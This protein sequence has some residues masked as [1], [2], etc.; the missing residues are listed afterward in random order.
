M[1]RKAFI[2]GITGQDGSYLSEYLLSKGYEVHGFIRRCSV[3]NTLRIK[4]LLRNEKKGLSLHFGDLSNQEQMI[5]VLRSVKPDE[6]Y[7]LGA[8]SQV[9]ISFDIPVYTGDITALGTTRM[10]SAIHSID[11]NIKFYQASSSEM[12]GSAS[13][14]QNE[15]TPFYP[16]SPYAISKLY[17]YWTTV[18]YREAYNIFSCNGIMFNHESPRRGS[19]FV[20]KK[21]TETL[22]N[23]I[24]KKQ[25]KIRLGNINTKRDW[26]YAPDYVECMWKILQENIAEDYVIGSG[27]SHTVEEFL[28]N[29]FKYVGLD[30]QEYLEIDNQFYRPLDVECLVS[31]PSK[32]RKQLKTTF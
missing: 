6:I 32:A 30:Y 29:A 26:G 14:P 20:T 13:P 8:Q 17:A 5:S 28:K 23:I 11:P 9:K 4:H 3:P 18:N 31:D 25:H 10:L 16:R 7:H 12:F 24:N 19:N 15:K 1:T 21:I 22:A 27:H 2:T